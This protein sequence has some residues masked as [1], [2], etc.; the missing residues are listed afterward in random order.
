MNEIKDRVCL[1]TGAN[2]GIGLAIVESFLH[3][4]SAKIYAGVRSLDKARELVSRH[5]DAIAPLVIDYN[6][7]ETIQAAAK[8]AAD[9]EIVVSNAG[10]LN[11][12]RVTDENVIDS[13][14][15]ELEVN[16]YALLRMA[17]AFAPVLR[18]N[19]GGAFIQVNSIASLASFDDFATYCASKAAAYSFTQSLRRSF[20]GQNTALLS[21]HPGPIETDMARQAGMAGQG[22]AAEVVSEAIVESLKKGEFHLFPDKFAQLFGG[23]YRRFAEDIIEAEE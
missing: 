9:V 12:T 10:L 14:Q 21:V 17:R 7:P 4:G 15:E 8:A 22:E 2:R 6:Q 3:H 11:Q 16:V 5:G 18:A 13:F 20:A 19:G 1:V 23:A